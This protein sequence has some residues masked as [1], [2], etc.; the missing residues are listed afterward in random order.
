MQQSILRDAICARPVCQGPAISSTQSNKAQPVSK[1]HCS[2]SSRASFSPRSTVQSLRM[3][4]VANVASTRGTPFSAVAGLPT[5]SDTKEKFIKAYARPIPAMFNTILQELLVSQHLNRYNKKYAYSPVMAVGFCSVFDQIFSE[6][7]YG[8]AEEIFTAFIQALDESPE[9]YRTESKALTDAAA[10]AT[11][12]DAL[13][14]MDAVKG[15]NGDTVLHSKFTAI[16]LFRLLEVS[17]KTD[18]AALDQV[19]KASGM[20]MTLVSRDLMTYKGL[21]SK[22]DS[23]KELMKEM[24]ARERKQ[25]A[26]RM[27]EKAAKAEAAAK[28]EETSNEA[29]SS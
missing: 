11:S 10:A 26:E 20:D 16:G 18:A 21:L 25:T 24:M 13:C 14:E 1:A 22:L 17:G 19:V 12:A 27:A 8:N 3:S 6:Y 7:K 5:V 28:V 29:A 9:Q 4:R 23:T 2:L 15:I